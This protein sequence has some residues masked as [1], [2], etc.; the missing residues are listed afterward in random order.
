MAKGC[1]REKH[2]KKHFRD[3]Y[4]AAATLRLP[5]LIDDALKTKN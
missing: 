3:H 1:M 4:A 5:L 2:V